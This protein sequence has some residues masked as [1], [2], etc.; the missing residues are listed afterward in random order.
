MVL[1]SAGAGVAGFETVGA[2]VVLTILK[3]AISAA[4]NAL[5]YNQVGGSATGSA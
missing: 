3:E 4:W 5:V 2:H 1:A